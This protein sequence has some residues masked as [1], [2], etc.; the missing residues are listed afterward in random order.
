LLIPHSHL[1]KSLTAIPEFADLKFS[2]KLANALVFAEKGNALVGG[3]ARSVRYTCPPLKSID[4]TQAKKAKWEGHV[5]APV[6]GAKLENFPSFSK[7]CG[8]VLTG[9]CSSAIYFSPLC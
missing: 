2:E 9:V 8:L 4:F 1:K 5:F 7:H 6:F 3:T